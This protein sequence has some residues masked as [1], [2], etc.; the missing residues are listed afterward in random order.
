MFSGT[1]TFILLQSWALSLRLAAGTLD[2]DISYNDA[3]TDL[4]LFFS[5][6]FK[7]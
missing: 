4:F 5:E 6:N 3:E 2:W 1:G 7:G